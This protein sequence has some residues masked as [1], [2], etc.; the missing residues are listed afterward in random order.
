MYKQLGKKPKID[1]IYIED[2]Y[3]SYKKVL[4]TARLR[5]QYLIRNSIDFQEKMQ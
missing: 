5:R 1:I 2:F 3:N 4:T